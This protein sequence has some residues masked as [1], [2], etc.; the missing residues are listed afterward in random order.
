MEQAVEHPT[1]RRAQS[2]TTSSRPS[3]A[4][5]VL[6]VCVIVIGK[7]NLAAAQSLQS[8]NF[9]V[10][11]LALVENLGAAKLQMVEIV[12]A[13]RQNA[14]VFI[15][16]EPTAS[17]K[18]EETHHLFHL[19][20]VLRERGAGI[21]FIAHALREALNLA[22]RI[23]VLRDGKRFATVPSKDVTRD[24]LARMLIGRDVTIDRAATPA[25]PGT[26][27]RGEK[28]LSVE[29]VTMGSVV[30][31]MSFSLFA[32]EVVGLSGLV[33][34]GRSEIA[35]VACGARKRNFPR[36]GMIYSAVKP[37]RYRV[38]RRAVR[39]DIA[40]ITED[41]ELDGFFETMTV[42]QNLYLGHLASPRVRRFLYSR[43]EMKRVTN[44]WVMALSISAL[45]RSLKIVEYSGGNQ[46]KVV[47]A[48]L[49]V[50]EASVI[51]L[52]ESTRGSM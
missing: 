35:Q 22:D 6:G 40:H 46:Q 42:D 20:H 24:E 3:Q 47:V 7:I 52:D 31:N 14:K 2:Q 19:L 34:A 9:N 13:V 5:A 23:T 4:F 44:R 28:V 12:R 8:L 43:Q 17:L 48:K 38:S 29:N 37:L 21:I 18:P 36:G 45:K 32:G 39:D 26:T 10:H 11:A 15:V 41:R 51:V 49:L 25:E 50:Q 27:S 30:K 33:G 1:T 16:D